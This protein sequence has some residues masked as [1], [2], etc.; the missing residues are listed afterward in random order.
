MGALAEG[1]WDA[2]WGI[3]GMLT[4]AAVFAEI[5]PALKVTLLSWG[6][7]GRLTLP[8]LFQVNHWLIIAGFWAAALGL[9][10]FFRKQGF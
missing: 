5:Y 1:R 6:N 7:Y 2:L 8:Q 4:G 9:F 10:A 3:L